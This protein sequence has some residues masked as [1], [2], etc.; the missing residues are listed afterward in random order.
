MQIQHVTIVPF[1]SS[2]IKSVAKRAV[3]DL[4]WEHAGALPCFFH[5][6]VVFL[7]TEKQNSRP[8]FRENVRSRRKNGDD[9]GIFR[10]ERLEQ[11]HFGFFESENMNGTHL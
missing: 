1:M 10:V 2:R 5:H 7:K 9:S 4:L 11:R 3:K 6:V 8:V